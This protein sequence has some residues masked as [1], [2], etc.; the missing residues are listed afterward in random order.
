MH[1]ARAYELLQQNDNLSFGANEKRSKDREASNKTIEE[2][3]VDFADIVPVLG[4][5]YEKMDART[6][7]KFMSVKPFSNEVKKMLTKRA[8]DDDY[9]MKAL[10]EATSSNR[11]KESIVDMDM[12]YLLLQHQ[13]RHAEIVNRDNEDI[14]MNFCTI[15]ESHGSISNSQ[16]Q[17]FEIS[18]CTINW[19]MGSIDISEQ[20]EIRDNS[21]FFFG[22]GKNNHEWHG[23]S[24]QHDI[25]YEIRLIWNCKSQT[26]TDKNNIYELKAICNEGDEGEYLPC[27]YPQR[28]ICVRGDIGWAPLLRA[29]VLMNKRFMKYLRDDPN[30]KELFPNVEE[31]LQDHRDNIRPD[32]RGEGDT[33][34]IGSR[35]TNSHLML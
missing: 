20:I 28:L 34:D 22:T 35:L 14:I 7:R 12:I 32:R 29:V 10:Q 6:L 26:N 31:L 25:F 27:K 33:S 8:E 30:A 23:F 24:I 5:E 13:P 2:G 15:D 18:G 9:M 19:D 3:P 21:I 4:L 11:S 1:I 16:G 17:S